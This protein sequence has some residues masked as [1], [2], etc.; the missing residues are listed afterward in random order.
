MLVLICI[1]FPYGMPAQ[2]QFIAALPCD[3]KPAKQQAVKLES[4]LHSLHRF[5]LFPLARPQVFLSC[6]VK[7]GLCGFFPGTSNLICATSPSQA[8]PGT[9]FAQVVLNRIADILCRRFV[10]N[11]IAWTFS[12]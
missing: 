7:N 3:H 8:H 5:A 11:P 6:G 12:A 2:R 1:F 10:D 9:G 4:D